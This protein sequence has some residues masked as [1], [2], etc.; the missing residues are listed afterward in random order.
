MMDPL[1]AIWTEKRIAL[2]LALGWAQSGIPYRWGGDDPI[3]GFDCS[4]ML[5]ELLRQVG[6]LK[7][8]ERLSAAGL[9]QRFARGFE[10]MP[11][12]LTG[13]LLFFG[14]PVGHCA[15]ALDGHSMIE[16]G[17]GD[18]GTDTEDE[19]ARSNAFVRIRPINMRQ[20]LTHVVRLLR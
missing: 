18:S 8:N 5:S 6:R 11:P 10:I 15:I 16:A 13:D 1:A 2:T 3:R 9:Y 20:D 7:Y 12:V 14:T 17:G 19:A 4:G